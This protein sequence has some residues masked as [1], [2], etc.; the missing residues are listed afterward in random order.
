MKVGTKGPGGHI[1]WV[2][3]QDL[4]VTK[5]F[6]KFKKETD[7]LVTNLTKELQ[8]TKEKL[9]EV[10]LDNVDIVKGLISR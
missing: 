3:I 7:K 1:K 9:E 8:V 10:K 2:D 5:E 6:V 4:P